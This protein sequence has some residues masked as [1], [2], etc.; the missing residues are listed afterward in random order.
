NIYSDALAPCRIGMHGAWFDDASARRRRRRQTRSARM[1]ERGGIWPGRMQAEIVSE[2]IALDPHSS[3]PD[4]YFRYGLEVLGPI[5]SLFVLGLVERLRARTP[6][7]LMFLARDGHLFMRMYTRWRELDDDMALPD[8][9]Y[10]YASRRVVASAAVADGLTP[11]M[12]P[13]ALA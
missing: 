9:D 3:D 12:L 13:I 6:E 1:A 11:E 2:R 10:V 8:P 7:R 4:P 5:F